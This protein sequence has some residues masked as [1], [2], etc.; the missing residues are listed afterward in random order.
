MRSAKNRWTFFR[1]PKTGAHVQNCPGGDR[2]H[3]CDQRRELL[4]VL[5]GYKVGRARMIVIGAVTQPQPMWCDI[6]V[7]PL[8]PRAR[9]KFNQNDPVALV[10]NPTARLA[11]ASASNRQQSGFCSGSNDT[12]MFILLCHF[13]CSTRVSRPHEPG[14]DATRQ[15]RNANFASWPLQLMVE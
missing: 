2:R 1:R 15:P 10:G 11:D 9:L 5:E 8:R 4:C 3:I 14:D 6:Q 12:A 13:M 7:A